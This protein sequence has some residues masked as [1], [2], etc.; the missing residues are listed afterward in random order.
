MVIVDGIDLFPGITPPRRDNARVVSYDVGRGA[1]KS[2]SP[3]PHSTRKRTIV[4][5]PVETT[6]A[7]SPTMLGA[8]HK[9]WRPYAPESSK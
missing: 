6:H 2:A 3:R 1:Q 9:N 4:G 7:L 8:A 5:F